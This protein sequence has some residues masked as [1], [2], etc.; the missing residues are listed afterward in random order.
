MNLKLAPVL[1]I[2]FAVI[3][4]LVPHPPNMAP[5]TAM[6]LFSGAYLP[7]KYA[8]TLP[9]IAM[10]ISDYFIGFYGSTMIF[11]YGSFL[12]VGLLGT[13]LKNHK[14]AH[15]ILGAS[16]ISSILFF[17]I[18]NFGVWLTTSLYARNLPGL[19]N[20][21]TMAIPFFRNTIIGDLVFTTIIFVLYNLS[22]QLAKKLLPANYFIWAY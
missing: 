9:I 7:N 14:Q 6:A 15:Y 11:V 8:F 17:L 5:I 2:A 4:R 10:L 20:C 13:W 19:L 12:L 18:T 1:M 3:M 16:L 22:K 21:Y